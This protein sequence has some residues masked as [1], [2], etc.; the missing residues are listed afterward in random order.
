MKVPAFLSSTRKAPVLILAVMTVLPVMAQTEKSEV[1][2]TEIRTEAQITTTSGDNTPLWLN[3]NKYGLSSLE[4]TNGYVRAGVF[5]S[6]D[7][8]SLRKVAFAYGADIAVAT[9]FTSRLI[10]QQA[11]GEMD[12]SPSGARSNPSNYATSNSAQ[13][14]R[15]WAPTGAPTLLSELLCPN[16]GKSRSPRD[17]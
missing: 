1:A 11:Y 5:R 12:C 10:I 8:D 16:T 15:H 13:D 2:Q 14:R 9:H 6:M 17:G 3:A 7:R 4:T